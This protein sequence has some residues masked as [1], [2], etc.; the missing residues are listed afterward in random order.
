MTNKYIK[1]K[2]IGVDDPLSLRKDKIYEAR[3]LKMNWY[4]ITDETGEEYAF[5]PEFFE[6]V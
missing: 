4:G 6:I 5:P 1:V 3:I 2:Y